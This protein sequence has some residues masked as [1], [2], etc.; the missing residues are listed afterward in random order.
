MVLKETKIGYK[1]DRVTLEKLGKGSKSFFISNGCTPLGFA[2]NIDKAY[3]IYEKKVRVLK[4][5]R[6]RKFN[7][8]IA[9]VKEN[10]DKVNLNHV[11]EIVERDFHADWENVKLN[12]C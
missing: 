5:R 3:F 1:N 2:D 8:L 11:K 4:A 7:E 9:Y 10:I 6:T 12:F